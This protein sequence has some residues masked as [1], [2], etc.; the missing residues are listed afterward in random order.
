MVDRRRGPSPL[1]PIWSA[2][3][4]ASVVPAGRRPVPLVFAVL[5]PPAPS[6]L[7][8]RSRAC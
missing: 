8:V 3:V 5:S 7:A 4:P 1:L 2:D 6:H